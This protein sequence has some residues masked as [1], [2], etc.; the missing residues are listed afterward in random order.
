VHGHRWW[1]FEEIQNHRGP[2]FLSPR[3]LPLLLARLRADGPAPEP[4]FI[5]L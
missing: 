1:T 3:N 4:L 2:E 5:G